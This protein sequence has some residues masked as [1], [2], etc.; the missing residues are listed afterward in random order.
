MLEESYPTCRKSNAPMSY[1]HQSPLQ[2]RATEEMANGPS[3]D[4][5]QPERFH[6]QPLKSSASLAEFDFGLAP[7][8]A[9]RD[10]Q[11]VQASSARHGKEKVLSGWEMVAGAND[12]VCS[13][14]REP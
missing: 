5:I 13:M 11:P 9:N 8:S 14:E 2:K 4:E 10:H 3:G 6:S 1:C 12:R 7:H